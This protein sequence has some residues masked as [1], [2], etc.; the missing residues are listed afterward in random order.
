MTDVDMTDDHM[1][2]A[3]G[4]LDG[5]RLHRGRHCGPKDPHHQAIIN[6]MTHDF[7]AYCLNDQTVDGNQTRDDVAL[8][9]T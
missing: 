2:S 3:A 9:L 1:A 8:F 4:H 5:E 6:P 7:R